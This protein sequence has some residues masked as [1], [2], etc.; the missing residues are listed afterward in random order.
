MRN[1]F[2]LAFILFVFACLGS[3][4]ACGD[5]SGEDGALVGGGND[6]D[7]NTGPNNCGYDYGQNP[8]CDSS[9]DACHMATLINDDREAN[10]EESDCA[11]AIKW[12]E[13]LAQVAY[14]HSK[15]MC[16]TGVFDHV[17]N[18]KDPFDRMD[19]AGIDYVAAGENIAMGTD[20][21]YTVDDFEV[22]FMDEPECQLNHRGNILSRD[23]THVGIGVHHC[24]D[25]NVY[26]TQDFA[27]YDYEDIRQDAHEFCEGA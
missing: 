25:G 5:D 17:V 20:G 10:P 22:S 11:P 3:F 4:F 24:S 13:D 15:E 21:Y 23:F 9:D 12:D 16:D 1:I 19:A 6:D 18:G 14:Q 2:F 26:V 7:D 8:G 27:S